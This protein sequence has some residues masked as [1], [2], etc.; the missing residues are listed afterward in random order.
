M[1]SPDGGHLIVDL[2]ISFAPARPGWELYG[3]LCVP[4]LRQWAA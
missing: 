2:P 1:T 3:F 4:R